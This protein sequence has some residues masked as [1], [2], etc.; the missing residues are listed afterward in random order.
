MKLTPEICRATYAL[1]AETEPFCN[2]PLPDADEVK[3]EVKR[4]RDRAADAEKIGETWLLRFNECWC[5]TLHGLTLHVMHE[6]CHVAHGETCPGDHAHH[7]KWFHALAREVCR[8]HHL[9]PK[10]F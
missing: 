8:V 9:D 4:F 10:A 1:I 6:M 5:G 2:W 7:G 3:F